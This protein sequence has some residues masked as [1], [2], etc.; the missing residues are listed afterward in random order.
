L[1]KKQANSKRARKGAKILALIERAK[2]ATLPEIM[3]ATDW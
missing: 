1:S 2:G 3:K